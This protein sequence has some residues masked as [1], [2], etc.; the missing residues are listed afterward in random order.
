MAVGAMDPHDNHHVIKT[1]EPLLALRRED[2][3][4]LLSGY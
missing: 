3:S 2:A 1:L 4:V